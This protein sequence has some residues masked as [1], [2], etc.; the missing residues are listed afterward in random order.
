[1]TKNAIKNKLFHYTRDKYWHIFSPTYP[2]VNDNGQ[3][4]GASL[5]VTLFPPKLACIS[6]VKFFLLKRTDFENTILT[7][8]L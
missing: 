8:V 1:M 2:S 4:F 5:Q 6:Y 7:E 3:F